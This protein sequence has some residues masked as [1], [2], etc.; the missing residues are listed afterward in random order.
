MKHKGILLFES[1]TVASLETRILDIPS[2]TANQRNKFVQFTRSGP[3]KQRTEDNSTGS[4]H[5]L[6]PLDRGVVL[7]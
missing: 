7:A 4:E 1:V 3:R 6:L 5:I 2:E